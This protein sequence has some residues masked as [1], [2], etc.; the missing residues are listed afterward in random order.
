[1]MAVSVTPSSIRRTAVAVVAF[2]VA[3]LELWTC[4]RCQLCF[5]VRYVAGDCGSGAK[6]SLLQRIVSVG[7]ACVI[8]DCSVVL[9]GW[10]PWFMF[11]CCGV[12]GDCAGGGGC[13]GFGECGV[14]SYGRVLHSIGAGTYIMLA[15]FGVGNEGVGLTVG[16]V[17]V[18][19]YDSRVVA[20]NGGW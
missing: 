13:V 15:V 8:L 4:C 6:V 11:C 7:V 2:A 19:A 1:M 17:G 14:G 16:V 12:M 5:G 10:L 20:G 9:V 3:C 18:D